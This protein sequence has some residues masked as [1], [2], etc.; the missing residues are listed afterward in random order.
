MALLE[1]LS[2]ALVFAIHRDKKIPLSTRCGMERGARM[3]LLRCN[4]NAP[5]GLPNQHW[6][7]SWLGR[8]IE[9]PRLVYVNEDWAIIGEVGTV[10]RRGI[11]K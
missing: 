1:D 5:G 8:L 10:R 6:E 11:Y 9:W 2:L 3:I 4:S 7:E